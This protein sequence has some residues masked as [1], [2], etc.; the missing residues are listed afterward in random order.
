MTLPAQPNPD[1]VEARMLAGEITASFG[2]LVEMYKRHLHYSHEDAIQRLNETN[3]QRMQSAL[4]CAPSQVEWPD[5]HAIANKDEA[6]AQQRWAE[7]KEAALD[8]LASGGRAARSMVPYHESPWQRAKACALFTELASEWQPRNGVERQLIYMMAQAQ[9]AYMHWLETLN[10]YANQES[11]CDSRRKREESQWQ[12]RRQ[13]D[14]DAME[15]AAAMADRFNKIFLRTLRALRDLRRQSPPV[16]LQ[17]GGQLNVAQQQ[18]N[19][20]GQGQRSLWSCPS[21][22]LQQEVIAPATTTPL[23]GDAVLARMLLQQR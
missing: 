12:A 4:E 5:L 23:H 14:A 17:S 22:H 6:R 7:I 19:V 3:D 13:R 21:K 20:A 16:I 15:Q 1:Q 8:E 11:V 18:V 2:Q 10:T 9:A